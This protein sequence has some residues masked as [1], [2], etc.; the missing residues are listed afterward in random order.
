MHAV[1]SVQVY[2]PYGVVPPVVVVVQAN[3]LPTV[4]VPQLGAVVTTGCPATATVVDA[5]ALVTVFAS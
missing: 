3:A 5:D 4:A 1:G 2:G